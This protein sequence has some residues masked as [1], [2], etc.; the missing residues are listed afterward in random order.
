MVR[1]SSA[2]K[3][4]KVHAHEPSVGF[5]A[6]ETWKEVLRAACWV[7]KYQ[8]TI[9][10]I[11]TSDFPWAG[12]NGIHYA[13]IQRYKLGCQTDPSAHPLTH[14][15][16]VLRRN[17]VLIQVLSECSRLSRNWP[18][19]GCANRA[20]GIKPPSLGKQGEKIPSQVQLASILR[21]STHYFLSNLLLWSV[22]HI[23]VLMPF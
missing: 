18:L 19:R 9:I 4:L 23:N 6:Y 21:L 12:P 11:L 14:A 3:P 8:F 1:P 20:G 16:L 10:I 15:R 7:S 5:L 2:Q 13:D 17:L 22:D